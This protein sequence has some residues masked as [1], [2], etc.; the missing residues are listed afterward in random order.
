MQ[1]APKKL[2]NETVAEFNAKFERL[3]Q[4]IP[5]F[6][7][8]RGNHLLFLYMKDFHCNF[9]YFLKNKGPKTI[10]EAKDMAMKIEA[11]LSSCR[12]DLFYA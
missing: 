9:G 12:V 8:L 2:E 7:H 1:V 10:H 11:N 4:Q 3:L 6:H 5:K